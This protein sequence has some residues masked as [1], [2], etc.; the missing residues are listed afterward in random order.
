MSSLVRNRHA[1]DVIKD[2]LNAIMSNLYAYICSFMT[3]ELELHTY[4]YQKY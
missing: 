2:K 4:K 3:G 1:M